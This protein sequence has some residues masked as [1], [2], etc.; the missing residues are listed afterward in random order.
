VFVATLKSNWCETVLCV[1]YLTRTYQ[2]EFERLHTTHST[3][4]PPR[5]ATPRPRR[6]DHP[7]RFKNQYQHVLSLHSST[8]NTYPSPSS[9]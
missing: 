5:R 9:L 4:T 1:K 6:N 3:H 2:L 8:R 7:S